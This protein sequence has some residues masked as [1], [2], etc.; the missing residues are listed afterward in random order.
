MFEYLVK[1]LVE[2]KIQSPRLEARMII[3][4]VLQIDYNQDF[5]KHVFL[6]EEK[7]KIKEMLLQRLC[8]KPLDKILGYKDF[9]KHSFVVSQD[10]LSPRADS[11]ILVEK[12]IE[13]SKQNNFKNVLELG[14]GSGCL[15]LSV[16]ADLDFLQGVGLDKSS[17]AI[18]IAKKN[19]QN[20][21]VE[22][23]TSFIEGD[24]FIDIIDGGFDMI[25]TN[26]PYIPTADILELDKEVRE[27]DPYIALDGGDDGYEHY[28]QIAKIAPKLLNEGG[29]ILIEA[30]IGQAENISKIFEDNGL[31]HYKSYKDLSGINRC[32]ILKK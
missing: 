9:Y 2:G 1:K 21:G 4:H 15:L 31:H 3:T 7:Q 11:E 10:V 18:E 5:E 19:A 24:Y 29:Y 27:Y 17:K 30:G 12:A 16:V 26:P 13:I 23:R 22:N 20:I 25:I 14:V 8:H 28:I 6:E 32:V